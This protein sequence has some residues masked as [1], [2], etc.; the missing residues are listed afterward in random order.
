MKNFL[1]LLFILINYIANAQSKNIYVIIDNKYQKLFKFK[2]ENNSYFSSIRILKYDKKNEGF[3]KKENS[4]KDDDIIV[5][6]KQPIETNYY[7]FQS[8]K[9]PKD[10]KNINNLT[11][12]NIEEISRNI[13]PIQ[14]IWR[15]S[16]Y[17]I[18][19]IEKKE[20]NYILWQM[21][22]IYLE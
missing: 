22:P 20:C 8:Y 7:E 9:K 14:K 4:H 5:I 1:I 12:Y 3:N 6:S 13:K 18:V 17:S 11:T 10:T 21:K 19:F 16:D 2:K 15:N